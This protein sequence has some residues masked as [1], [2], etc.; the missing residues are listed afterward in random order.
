MSRKKSIWNCGEGLIFTGKNT[1]MSIQNSRLFYHYSL[2][3]TNRFKW[4]NLPDGVRSEHIEENLYHHGQVLFFDDDELGLLTLP[5]S[6]NGQLNVYG[7]PKEFTVW[8]VNYNKTGI[9]EDDSV[10]IKANDLCF[11]Q[12]LQVAHYTNLLDEI[13]KTMEMNLEQQR[14]PFIIP[15]TKKNELSMKNYYK[16]VDEGEKAIFVDEKLSESPNEGIKVLNTQAPYLLTDLQFHKE[17]TVNELLT[18]LGINNLAVNKRERLV[19]GEVE[20]NNENIEMNLQTEYKNR[21]LA[22]EEINKKFGLN[23]TVTKVVNLMN[24]EGD[25]DGEIYPRD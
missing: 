11:P 22:C 16:K 6:S 14:F 13:E 25:D 12:V 5:C 18:I 10:R 21:L 15:T 19:T 8:G 4:E 1:S 9:K 3:A 24:K 7:E 20:V 2:L 23:I 17:K